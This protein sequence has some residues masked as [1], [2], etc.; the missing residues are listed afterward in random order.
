[1]HTY[2]PKHWCLYFKE[3]HEH[4][5]FNYSVGKEIRRIDDDN[6]E[7][8]IVDWFGG[9]AETHKGRT[10]IIIVNKVDLNLGF[11]PRSST[12]ELISRIRIIEDNPYIKSVDE[13]WL[14]YTVMGFTDTITMVTE[15]NGVI[16]TN[17]LESILSKSNQIYYFSNKRGTAYIH[18]DDTSL[19]SHT[20]E[21]ALSS[22]ETAKIF[23]LRAM[24]EVHERT[25]CV[26][27]ESN[28]LNYKLNN[29]LNI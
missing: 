1:M 27:N 14:L 8:E 2:P 5:E 21:I 16:N 15:N 22:L 11:L 23:G 3:G 17:L 12:D 20:A 10:G 29:I 18:L 24:E 25:M 13:I 4:R 28:Y 19:I 26:V 6:T 9:K 7:L